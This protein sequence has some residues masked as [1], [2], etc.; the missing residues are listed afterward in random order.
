MDLAM[1]ALQ[2]VPAAAPAPSYTHRP[3]SLESTIPIRTSHV[4]EV[5]T[6]IC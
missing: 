3:A 6:T 5:D 2:V 1:P 4:E